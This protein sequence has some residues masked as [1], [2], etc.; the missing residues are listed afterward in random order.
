MNFADSTDRLAAC[1]L[2]MFSSIGTV[3]SSVNNIFCAIDTNRISTRCPVDPKGG[4][5]AML[6]AGLLMEGRPVNAQATPGGGS[7]R[8]WPCG[9][10]LCGR[11]YV[12]VSGPDTA[13]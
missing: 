2:D 6:V 11:P 8:P 3:S 10:F 12:A 5:Y 13:T 7:S 4:G 1:C 9:R